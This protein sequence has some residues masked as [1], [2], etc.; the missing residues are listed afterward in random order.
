MPQGALAVAS[1]DGCC[2]YQCGKSQAPDATYVLLPDGSKQTTAGDFKGN[3]G[4]FGDQLRTLHRRDAP[5]TSTHNKYKER[6]RHRGGGDE[7]RPAQLA[8]VNYAQ[9]CMLHLQGRHRQ[10]RPSGWAAWAM[11]S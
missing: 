8:A 3:F 1:P 4:E 11:C 5:A 10:H 2:S 6:L 9:T 7:L